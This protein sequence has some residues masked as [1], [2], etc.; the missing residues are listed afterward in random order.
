MPVGID[1]F[2]LPSLPHYI[3]ATTLPWRSVPLKFYF[4]EQII[5]PVGPGL[6]VTLYLVTFIVRAA[7]SPP[8]LLLQR[9]LLS[10][11]LPVSCCARVGM[12]VN[13]LLALVP[14]WSAAVFGLLGMWL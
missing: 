14:G 13:G 12:Y 8:H 3:C 6:Y 5:V 7:F 11:H 1:A 10:R 2:A 4:S 9:R